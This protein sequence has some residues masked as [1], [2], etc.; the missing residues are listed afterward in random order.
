MFTYASGM[1][2]DAPGDRGTGMRRGRG[3]GRDLPNRFEGR[4]VE[5]DPDFLAGA[6]PEESEPSPRTEFLDDASRSVLTRN[7]S[8]DLGFAISVNPY[9]GCEHGCSYCYARPY[10]EYLGFSPGLEF[11]TRIVVK[12]QAASLLE[13]ELSRPGYHP[14]V[15]ALSGVTDAW[16]PVEK[17]LGITRACLEVLART[18]H[19]VKIVTKNRLVL[20][21]LDHLA[22]LA[23]HGAVAVAI[24]VTTLRDELRR[25]LEPRTSSVAARLET[26][27]ALS[28]AGVPVGALLA[29]II[30]ALTDEE[31]PDLVAAV[32]G[33]GASF[34]GYTL[35]RLPLGVAPLFED[36]LRSEVP[37]R[38]D[39]VL[40]QVREAHRGRLNDTRPGKRMKG[41]GARA[42][43]VRQLFQAACRRHGLATRG[44][45][46]RTDAFVPPGG[47][48][49]RLFPV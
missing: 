45:D 30:P 17:R 38:A 35:L 26:I 21:D 43:A 34:A 40:G 46:L 41:D 23:E 24:S 10:H 12:R 14:E 28:R 32:A 3:T 48:Q 5:P 2:E 7:D 1:A 27:R 13:A 44:P 9:R 19:P 36:W 33:A 16:Q 47:R 37:E 6:D 15:M 31:V 8:P 4:S 11:E 25:R 39:R 29:P 49:L 18:R 20:R 22:A 42:E